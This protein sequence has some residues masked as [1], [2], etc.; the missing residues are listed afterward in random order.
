MGQD[1]E[2]ALPEVPEVEDAEVTADLEGEEVAEESAKAAYDPQ[3]SGVIG[4]LS[5][6]H[7]AVLGSG[8]DYTTIKK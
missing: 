1:E 2:E 6:K 3:P 8:K 7:E 5:T 4:Q